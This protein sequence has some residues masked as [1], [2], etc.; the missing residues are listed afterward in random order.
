MPHDKERVRSLVFYIQ[1][2]SYAQKKKKRGQGA[3]GPSNK[4][5]IWVYKE[6]NLA[7]KE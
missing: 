5:Q 1:L 6:Q 2:E 7:N 3:L 4:E